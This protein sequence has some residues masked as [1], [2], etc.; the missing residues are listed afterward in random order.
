MT[1]TKQEMENGESKETSEGKEKGKKNMY[2][3]GIQ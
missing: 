2:E 1:I 3:K